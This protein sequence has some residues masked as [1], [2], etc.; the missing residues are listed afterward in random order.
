LLNSLVQAQREIYQKG[1]STKVIVVPIV[2]NY[3]F[4][5]EA[6]PLIRQY[7]R[8]LGAE[9]SLTRSPKVMTLK[10]ILRFVSRIIRKHSEVSISFGHPIDV[11]GNPLD[12]QLHSLDHKGHPIDLKK[13]LRE[14]YPTYDLFDLI[15]L[16]ERD[17]VFDE[18]QLLQKVQHYL[19]H[20]RQLAK[21]KKIY[22]SPKL[23][24]ATPPVIL[25]DGIYHLG[26]YHMRRPLRRD[27]KGRIISEDFKKL[28]YYHNRLDQPQLWE[29]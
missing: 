13:L 1:L 28:F 25:N 20:L 11:L 15:R 5:L 7:L 19:Q 22:L 26:A 17:F 27:G 12:A 16:D 14:K 3:H 24:H 10:N 23:Q 21:A 6:G 9:R 18:D 2:L 4:V 8:Q 29:K